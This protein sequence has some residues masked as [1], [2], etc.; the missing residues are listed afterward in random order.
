MRIQRN[1]IA[2][3]S[4]CDTEL[5]DEQLEDNIDELIRVM[6]DR[7]VF[8]GDSKYFDYREVDNNSLIFEQ[9]I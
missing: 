7:F 4:K 8:G 5:T 6:H 1:G 2:I 9:G 3:T